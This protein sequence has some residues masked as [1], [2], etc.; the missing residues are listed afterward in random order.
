MSFFKKLKDRLF[1]SSDK[2]SDGLDALVAE[3]A[4]DADQAEPQALPMADLAPE[5]PPELAPL[6][7]ACAGAE[8][9]VSML[10]N[11]AI[12]KAVFENEVIGH[13]PAGAVLLDNLEGV[14]TEAD[15]AA[16]LP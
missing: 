15:G 12:V 10:P 8:A 14:T 16:R 2:I 3:G 9:V 4:A 1:R 6:I 7:P 13:A 11:G 5:V